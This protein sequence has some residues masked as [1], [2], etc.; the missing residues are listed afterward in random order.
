VAGV[1]V[2][3]MAYET[4]PTEV[5]KVTSSLRDVIVGAYAAFQ[6]GGIAITWVTADTSRWRDVAK[7]ISAG[8][9]WMSA[10]SGCVSVFANGYATYRYFEE[11]D[12][13]GA[14]LLGTATALNGIATI[15]A[16][17]TAVGAAVPPALA[18]AAT[19]AAIL[20]LIDVIRKYLVEYIPQKRLWER[21]V[22]QG[23]LLLAPEVDLAS[24][25]A[26]SFSLTVPLSSTGEVD[27]F[28]L[29]L[30]VPATGGPDVGPGED[31]FLDLDVGTGITAMYAVLFETADVI[32]LV[33]PIPAVISASGAGGDGERVVFA[34]EVLVTVRPRYES[35]IEIDAD[36]FDVVLVAEGDP[37]SASEE[38]ATFEG[39]SFFAPHDGIVGRV[40]SGST[41]EHD[42]ARIR[43]WAVAQ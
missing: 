24:Q 28:E 40:E 27:V 33:C 14:I 23:V 1:V 3:Q 5:D 17:A 13:F 39:T 31:A 42:H 37:V 4:Q 21:V 34:D 41:P 25:I 30:F 26:G 9:N 12:Y 36:D 8:G 10:F 15:A 11:E 38:V 16:F 20:V 29:G 43:I 22:G 7:A 19:I 32:S 35:W 18:V 6:I 2:Y